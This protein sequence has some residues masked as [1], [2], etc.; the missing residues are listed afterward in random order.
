MRESSSDKETVIVAMSGGVDSSVA[1]GLLKQQDYNVIGATLI[2]CSCN[3]DNNVSWRCGRGAEENA[4]A[5]CQTLGI[6]HYAIDC[7]EKFEQ[8]VLAPSWETYKSGRTPSPC[9]HCNGKIKFKL[10]IDLA[11]KLG[12]TK[13]A[14]GHYAIIEP[15]YAPRLRRGR[16][17]RKDQSYFLFTLSKEQL[18]FTLF[19]LGKLTKTEVRALAGQMNFANAKRPESQD[20]CFVTA[21]GN[22]AEALRL[23]FHDKKESGNIVSPDG[24][25]L[26]THE[27]V[28]NYTIGQRKGLGVAMGQKAYVTRIDAKNQTVELSTNEQDLLATSLIARNVSWIGD[29]VPSLP[30]TCLAQIRYR[31]APA[32]VTAHMDADNQL[33]I[34]F[35]LPQ[36]AVAPGQAVVL[37]QD[38]RVIGG[39]WIEKGR[40]P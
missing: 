13:I 38:D 1:A 33:V 15:G 40:H 22:F 10:L 5:V 29:V 24:K 11:K 16:Y 4:R 21:K 7:A 3:D 25:V 37:Y 30:L 36:K 2:L 8:A 35:S 18:N 12:A 26:G 39:G 28:Y 23:R 14:T 6:R 31:S 9:I 34:T 32:E 27:G 20:A 19:P 17:A